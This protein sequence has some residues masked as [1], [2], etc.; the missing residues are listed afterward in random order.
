MGVGRGTLTATRGEGMWP[1][2]PLEFRPAEAPAIGPTNVVEYV[3]RAE[4]ATYEYLWDHLHSKMSHEKPQ[5]AV[6]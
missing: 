3:K 2:G 5:G 4:G 1:I 6:L